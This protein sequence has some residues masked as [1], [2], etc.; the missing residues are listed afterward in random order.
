[1]FADANMQYVFQ[2]GVLPD[3]MRYFIGKCACFQVKTLQQQ[4]SGCDLDKMFAIGFAL[5]SRI[6]KITNIKSILIVTLIQS[7]S[8]FICFSYFW[9]CHLWS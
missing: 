6:S 9:G 8:L 3:V 4:D 1:M 7:Q 5:K 2:S